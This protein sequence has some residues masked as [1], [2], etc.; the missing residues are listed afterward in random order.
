[1]LGIE[2][3]E[4][5]RAEKFCKREKYSILHLDYELVFLV[6]YKVHYFNLYYS[7]IITVWIFAEMLPIIYTFYFM[8]QSNSSLC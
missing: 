8:I 3:G 2:K 1:M 4:R 7:R 6:Y 5:E